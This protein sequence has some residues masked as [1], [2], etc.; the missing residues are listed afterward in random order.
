M[1]RHAVILKGAKSDFL[2]IR[3]YV[4]RQFSDLVWAEVN[5]EFKDTIQRIAS[6]PLLGTQLEELAGLG[7]GGDARCFNANLENGV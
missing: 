3:K 2:E 5:H 6:N 7:L 1:T 4:K